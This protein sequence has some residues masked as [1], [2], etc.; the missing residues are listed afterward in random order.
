MMKAS[1]GSVIPEVQYVGWTA[2]DLNKPGAQGFSVVIDFGGGF[3]ALHFLNPKPVI[4]L[5]ALVEGQWRRRL[6]V[7]FLVDMPSSFKSFL[8]TF[9]MF[10]KGNTRDKIHFISGSEETVKEL[11]SLGCEEETLETARQYLAARRNP[12]AN[13]QFHP[14]IDYSFF[15]E[16]M[17]EFGLSQDTSCLTEEAHSRLR[18]AVQ[19]FRISR[20]GIPA[21]ICGAESGMPLWAKPSPPLYTNCLEWPCGTQRGVAMLSLDPK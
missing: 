9:L 18:D 1:L 6:K 2:I 13:Q 5:A 16:R 20:W 15:R 17:A 12:S 3:N 19:E 11:E 10:F 21:R 14:I 7:A 8:T 4:D